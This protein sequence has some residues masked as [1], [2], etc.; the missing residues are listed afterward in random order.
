MLSLISVPFISI[1][2]FVLFPG[3]GDS[4]IK[5]GNLPNKKFE[6]GLSEQAML[7]GKMSVCT[8]CGDFFKLFLPE[9]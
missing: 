4:I 1:W 9:A 5:Q 7:S 3:N 8:K 2:R 6:C